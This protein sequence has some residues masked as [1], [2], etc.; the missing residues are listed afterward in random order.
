VCTCTTLHA[1][2]RWCPQYDS[3]DNG[4]P[5][6]MGRCAL[7]CLNHVPAGPLARSPIP[8]RHPP[9]RNGCKSG[10]QAHGLRATHTRSAFPS[11]D[12]ST[13]PCTQCLDVHSRIPTAAAAPRTVNP[14][15]RH[16]IPSHRLDS[17]S[18]GWQH[19]PTIRM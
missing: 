12:A 1:V 16:L 8:H 15:I 18:R 19:T 4:Q 11:H 13:V 9:G 14:V 7:V 3:A 5:T 10:M 17:A 6:S 2:I